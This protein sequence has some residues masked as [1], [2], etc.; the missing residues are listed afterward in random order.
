MKRQRRYFQWLWN[1]SPVV[2]GNLPVSVFYLSYSSRLCSAAWFSFWEN[3]GE[4]FIWLAN[5]A[6][7]LTT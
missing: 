2:K 1:H 3:C 6:I 5:T 4:A 7:F